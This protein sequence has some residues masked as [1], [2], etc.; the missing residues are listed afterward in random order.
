MFNGRDT[1]KMEE[2]QMISII[3]VCWLQ[4][5]GSLQ[6]RKK[7]VEFSTIDLEID[8]IDEKFLFPY[9]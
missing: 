4:Y 9:C 8:E 7:S 3:I 1:E 5:Y 6:K 2:R